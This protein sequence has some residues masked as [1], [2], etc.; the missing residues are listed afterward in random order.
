[1]TAALALFAERGYHGTCVPD[2]AQRAGVAVGTIYRH[3]PTKQALVNAVYLDRK[4]DLA[5]VTAAAAADR[6]MSP[7]DQALMVWRAC[8]AWAR[9]DMTAF[10]FLELHHH[11]DY[12]DAESRAASDAA[13]AVL[14]DQLA[15]ARRAGAIRAEPSLEVL[16]VLLS[17]ILASFV[18]GAEDGAFTADPRAID[19]AGAA[20]WDLVT[21]RR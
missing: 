8:V 1:M 18:R 12:L 11:A 3:F 7:R 17:G 13:Q 16:V 9:A 4:N 6:T 14:R 19:A 20:A 2:I 15:E 21:G 5:A 10:R